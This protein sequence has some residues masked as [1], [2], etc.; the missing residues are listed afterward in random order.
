MI[1]VKCKDCGKEHIIRPNKIGEILY[2]VIYWIKYMGESCCKKP[3]K[4][5]KELI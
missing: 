4:I 5:K 3:S 2:N 1:K